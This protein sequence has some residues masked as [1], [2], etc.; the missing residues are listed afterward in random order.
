[1][2]KK[3]LMYI[4]DYGE[5][6]FGRVSDGLI[7]N[8]Y[9]TGKWEILHLGI[10]YNDLVPVDVPWKL[11]PA[12]FYHPTSDGMFDA[13]DPFGFTKANQYIDSFDPDV[14]FMNNDFP[15][16]FQYLGGVEMDSA[17]AKHPSKKVI[18]S[19]LDSTP[20]P[21]A[22]A[23]IARAFD[24]TVAYTYWQQ[25]EMFRTDPDYPNEIPVLYHGVDTSVYYPIPKDEAK[26]MLSGIFRKYNKGKTIPDFRKK[27]ITYF[28]GTNQWRKDIPTLFRGYMEFRKLHPDEHMFLI[29]HTNAT[30]M[31]QVHGGWSLHNL[32]ELVGL[33]DAVLMQQANIF[34]QEEMNV[35]YNAADVL[36]FPTRGEGF[37]LPSIEAMATKTPVIA[38]KFGPQ[39]ELHN[40]KRG[41]F[42]DVDDYEPGQ[43]GAYSYFAKPSWRSLAQQL[44]YVYTHRDEATAV[45]ENAYK[46][47]IQHTWESKALALDGILTKVLEVPNGGLKSDETIPERP[48]RR[49]APKTK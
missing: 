9:E 32:R 3:K 18:Y 37:G 29:P 47:A 27:F 22:F 8:L 1:M 26:R 36:A 4:G 31:S 46:F 28:V 38:T 48:K 43:G 30:P 12:G 23:Q 14:V 45:A 2:T 44:E 41:Y 49:I 15:V 42:I 13:Y 21:P 35:F 10:N 25:S 33:N 17:I 39:E 11:I 40:N 24:S 5:T 20:F 19:P 6:G 16:V 7:K 34:T